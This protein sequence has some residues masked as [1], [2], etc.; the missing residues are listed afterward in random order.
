LE[1]QPVVRIGN[2]GSN[3]LVSAEALLRW[4]RP[5]YGLVPPSDFIPCLESSPG[6][7][8]VG[9]WVLGAGLAQ[10]KNFH[11]TSALG[12]LSVAVNIAARHLMAPS[13][14]HDVSSAIELAGVPARFVTVEITETSLLDDTAVA[15]SHMGQLRDLGVKIAIDDF[16]TGFTSINQLGILPIDILKIDASFVRGLRDPKQRSIV[17]MMIGV[18]ETLGLTVLAEGVET[19]EE[20]NMLVSMGCRDH[21]GF[22]YSRSLAPAVFLDRF[23]SRPNAERTLIP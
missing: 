22:L 13:I 5:G 19:V 1:Y 10:L 6:I 2:D 9:R 11:A 21:Q 18:G 15:C 14:V 8:D 16:G 3:R 17:A 23:A 20:A 4:Q 7:T 12:E